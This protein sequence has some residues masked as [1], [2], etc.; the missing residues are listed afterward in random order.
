[1]ARARVQ[2]LGGAEGGEA[3]TGAEIGV[4]ARENDNYGGGDD[5]DV[6]LDRLAGVSD[7]NDNYGGGDDNYPKRGVEMG[8]VEREEGRGWDRQK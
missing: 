5:D 2:G 6:V 8:A 1:M 7:G 3:G 4:G